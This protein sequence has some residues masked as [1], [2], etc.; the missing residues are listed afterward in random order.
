MLTRRARTQ[1]RTTDC[2]KGAFNSQ[3]CSEYGQKAPAGIGTNAQMTTTYRP[4]AAR[5]RYVEVLGLL[6]G[7]GED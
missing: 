4:Y 5:I 2:R 7:G 1:E 6:I 3:S